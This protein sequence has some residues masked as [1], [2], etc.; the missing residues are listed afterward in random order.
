LGKINSEETRMSQ[1]PPI[2]LRCP[3]EVSQRHPRTVYGD[4]RSR[5]RVVMNNLILHLYPAQ[6]PVRTCVYLYVGAGRIVGA[7]GVISP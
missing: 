5:L 7:A 3:G 4:R 2:S 1:S 6:V